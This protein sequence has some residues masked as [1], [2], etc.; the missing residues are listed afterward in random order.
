MKESTKDKLEA[1]GMTGAIVLTV[2]SAVA[3]ALLPIAFLVALCVAI[4][5]LIF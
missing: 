1:V 4:I 5:R 3:F 2:M